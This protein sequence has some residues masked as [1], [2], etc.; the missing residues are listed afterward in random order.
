MYLWASKF[1]FLE[2][3]LLLSRVAP[4]LQFVTTN[5]LISKESAYY[6]D[7][8]YK[9]L[10]SFVLPTKGYK[11]EK[12]CLIFEKEGKY[13]LKVKESYWKSHHQIQRIRGSYCKGF[14]QGATTSNNRHKHQK[15]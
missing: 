2:F 14:K 1:R 11:P 10:L 3:W 15:S 6:A 12:N 13:P 7:Y 4:Y 9:V 5:C 8:K